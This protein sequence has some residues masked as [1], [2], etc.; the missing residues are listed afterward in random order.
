MRDWY[1][2]SHTGKVTA[3]QT[4]CHFLICC[5]LA[6]HAAT[7]LFT[8]LISKVKVKSLSRARL[9]TSPWIIACTRL[10]R[11]WDFQGRSTGVGCH[12]LLQ[13]IFPTQGL[14]PGLSHCRQMLYRLSHQGSPLV[15]K[16]NP[17]HLSSFN[18]CDMFFH[19][20]VSLNSVYSLPGMPLL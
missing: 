18:R 1:V 11:P 2:T 4:S 9:F 7:L 6:Q 20:C 10:L 8:I 17:K 5:V 3:T 16:D 15:S 14:N 13:G 12:F 19:T